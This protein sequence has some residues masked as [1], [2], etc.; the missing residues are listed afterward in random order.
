MYIKYSYTLFLSNFTLLSFTKQSCTKCLFYI[1]GKK[2]IKLSIDLLATTRVLKLDMQLRLT[3]E[4]YT[5]GLAIK[6]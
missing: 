4:T 3:E 2:E 6:F 1:T 5:R